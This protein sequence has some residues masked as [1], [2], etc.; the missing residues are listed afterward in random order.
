[1]LLRAVALRFRMVLLGTITQITS[2][3]HFH[4]SL[5]LSADS[6]ANKNSVITV[7]FYVGTSYILVRRPPGLTSVGVYSYQYISAYEMYIINI[8]ACVTNL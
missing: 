6:T 3:H 2:L 4:W 7:L 8:T 5:L 1:M